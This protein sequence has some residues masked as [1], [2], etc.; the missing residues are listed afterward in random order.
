M[1]DAG[2]GRDA[3]LVRVDFVVNRN[4]WYW[5]LAKH[6]QGDIERLVAAVDVMATAVGHAL[7]AAV[8]AVLAVDTSLASQVLSGDEVINRQRFAIEERCLAILATQQPV[9]RD[10]RLLL[11]V[12]EVA[13]E[14]ERMG[15]YAKD[16][17]RIAL[18]PEAGQPRQPLQALLPMSQMAIAMLDAALTSF[19]DRNAELA[20]EVGRRDD[21]VDLLCGQVRRELLDLAHA[22]AESIN[23]IVQWLPA[24]HNIER[25]ADRVTNI[26]ERA[27]FVATG[28]IVE[29]G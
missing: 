24:V 1:A 13:T 18:R 11:A 27:V 25:F 16:I 12:L 15:D 14:L 2:L 4:S 20:R 26:C 5:T 19:R 17:A 29:F 6:L 7:P 23:Q 22:D 3:I 28:G 8:Q 9:A 21:E 10:A